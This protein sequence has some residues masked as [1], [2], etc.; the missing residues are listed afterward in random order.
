MGK[1]LTQQDKQT[2][3]KMYTEDKVGCV[4]I[5][6]AI[7]FSQNTVIN[8]LKKQNIAIRSHR[9]ASLKYSCNENFFDVIDT[10]EK[11]YWLGFMYADGYVTSSSLY[12]NGSVGLSLSVKDIEHIKRFKNDIQY[13]GNI[14]IYTTNKSSYKEGTQYCRVLINSPKLYQGA[15]K[16]GVVE[17][18]TNILLEPDIAQHLIVHFIRGYFD[19]DGCIARTQRSKGCLSFAVK[20]LGTDN[21]LNYI[22]DFIEEHLHKRVQKYYKRKPDQIV[23]SLELGGNK[24]ARKFLDVLYKNATV[25]LNRKYERYIE[26]CNLLDSRALAKASGVKSPELLE[27]NPKA[28]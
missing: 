27:H 26:L 2:I 18:K 24:D 1:H 11:A 5:S 22:N 7:G 13:D 14:K 17:H 19:G 3:L 25:Y 8:F 16:Q 6:K 15:V 9:E 20:I 23:S 28:N 12:S 4:T 21:I 10:E